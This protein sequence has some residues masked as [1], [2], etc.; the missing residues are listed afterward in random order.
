MDRNFKFFTA[1]FLISLPVWWSFNVWQGKLEDFFFWKAIADN[2]QILL[3]QMIQEERLAK[4]K[5]ISKGREEP[6]LEAEAGISVFINK[7]GEEKI[8]FK[9]NGQRALPIAS[10]TKL[11]TAY[12]ALEHYSLS[13][14]E[15]KN[16][17]Y[18][19]LI[20]SDNDSANNLAQKSVEKEAFVDELMNL[21]AEN[22]KM[23]NTFFINATGLDPVNPEDP[24]N[25]STAQDLVNLAKRISQ[26]QPIIW[27]ISALRE[28]EHLLNTNELLDEFPNILGGKTGWTPEAKGCLLIVLEAPR[29]RGQIVNVILGSPDRFQDMRILIDWVN[30][31]YKW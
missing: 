19:L 27:E 18:P 1:V 16:I 13:E 7:E 14:P 10:L 25:Y 29:G 5:P 8:L 17:I 11:M 30:E 20:A 31:A 21:E 22:L 23:T 9:K 6:R 15:I 2:P 3:A 24:L 28:Y 4:L 26:K 12:V